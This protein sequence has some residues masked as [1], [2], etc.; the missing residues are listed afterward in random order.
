MDVNLNDDIVE[1][2]IIALSDEDTARK[3]VKHILKMKESCAHCE[4]SYQEGRYDAY[5]ELVDMINNV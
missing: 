4:S 3:F 5:N 2:M 1:G